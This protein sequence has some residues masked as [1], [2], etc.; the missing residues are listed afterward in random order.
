MQTLAPN[1]A[2]AARAH[3]S[4][5]APKPARR[6]PTQRRARQTVAAIVE[7]AGRLLVE[8]GRMGV[9]TNA[10]AER[11]GVSIGSV[12]QY[13]PDKQ[14]IFAALQER[15]I[16]QVMPLVRHT[17]E[18]L[19]DPAV[20]IVD[21]LIGLMR[22]MAELHTDLPAHLRVV[23]DE[24]QE[25]T[26]P[27]DIERFA[28]ATAPILAARFGCAEDRAGAAAWLASMS[29]THI[30]RALVHHPPAIAREELLGAMTCMLRGLLA[31]LDEAR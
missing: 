2:K 30:G 27:E 6:A 14:A 1:R 13:F 21:A 16:E 5:R 10:V 11:A 26:S 29:L 4:V 24:Q 31:K 20:D 8:K 9:T 3:V 19:A 18:R 17:I 23:A 25:P 7:A 15:H 22:A 28:D 12:Y